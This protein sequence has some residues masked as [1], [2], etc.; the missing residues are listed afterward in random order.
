MPEGDYLCIAN[1]L[2]TAYQAKEGKVNS[3]EENWVGFWFPPSSFIMTFQEV[4]GN[5]RGKAFDTIHFYFQN[6][7]MNINSHDEQPHIKISFDINYIYKENNEPSIWRKWVWDSKQ[8]SQELLC[9]IY[10]P[11]CIQIHIRDS[12]F[13]C[14]HTEPNINYKGII[15]L[16]MSYATNFFWSNFYRNLR[17]S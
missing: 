9:T 4:K 2:Q 8:H 10:Q 12:V 17:H 13:E 5:L 3:E 7:E 1:A 11:R 15:S 14:R 6:I 16:V